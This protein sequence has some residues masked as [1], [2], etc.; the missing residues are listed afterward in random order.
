[1]ELYER[2]LYLHQA[3][4]ALAWNYAEYMRHD[5]DADRGQI[6]ADLTALLKARQGYQAEAEEI[7]R[8]QR[9]KS[10][11]W[12][13]FGGTPTAA[14]LDAWNTRRQKEAEADRAQIDA[15]IKA[16][17]TLFHKL[18]RALEANGLA[19]TG[20][21]ISE[22][23]RAGV[24]DTWA[25]DLEKIKKGRRAS[26]PEAERL[27]EAEATA[28]YNELARQGLISGPYTALV[29]HLG[30]VTGKAPKV[31]T[32]GLKWTGNKSEFAYFMRRFSDYTQYGRGTIREKA[33]CAAFGFDERARL[34]SIRPYLADEGAARA[35]DKEWKPRTG[36]KIDAAFAA[37]ELARTTST[38]N[39]QINTNI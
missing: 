25:A 36:S 34:N 38:N 6:R 33:L 26:I 7:E 32:E 3:P 19:L 21:Q 28:L 22:L 24:P 15:T 37:A 27:T 30:Q 9:E 16:L 29:Y 12:D 17:D 14:E 13:D 35:R 5:P 11:P 4:A 2:L 31:P 20:G 23:K 1:M 10:T 39:E 18:C 8:E